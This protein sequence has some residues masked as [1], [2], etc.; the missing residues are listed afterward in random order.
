MRF[1]V[2]EIQLQI[3][4]PLKNQIKKRFLLNFGINCVYALLNSF[5]YLNMWS[6]RGNVTSLLYAQVF[7]S[8]FFRFACFSALAFITYCLL[9][10]VLYAVSVSMWLFANWWNFLFNWKKTNSSRIH[11]IC[12]FHSLIV[13]GCLLCFDSTSFSWLLA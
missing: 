4:Y 11:S 2:Q 10:A 6:E 12:A 1:P 5:T 8:G 13:V 3:C 7:M 9:F